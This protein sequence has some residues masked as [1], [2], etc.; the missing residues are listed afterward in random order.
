MSS[1]EV[2]GEKKKISL[3]LDR[4]FTISHNDQQVQSQSFLARSPQ[5][6][7]TAA[8]PCHPYMWEQ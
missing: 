8:P 3:Y 6:V 7:L 4:T 2:K 5:W 1:F